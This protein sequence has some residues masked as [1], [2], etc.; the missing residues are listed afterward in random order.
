M[1]LRSEGKRTPPRRVTC[2]V[3]GGAPAAELARD[4][5]VVAL[6]EMSLH[7]RSHTLATTSAIWFG[8]NGRGTQPGKQGLAGAV[9]S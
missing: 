7:V 9:A 1:A 2:G 6:R 4:M 5:T 3:K 8:S